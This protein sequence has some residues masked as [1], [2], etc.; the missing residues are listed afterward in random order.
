MGV[1]A[2]TP[3]RLLLAPVRVAIAEMQGKLGV[4]QLEVSTG[5]QADVTGLLGSAI[6][7]SIDLRLSLTT[8]EQTLDRIEQARTEATFLQSSLG[9][10]SDLTESFR[11][12][13]VSSRGTMSHGNLVLSAA[14]SALNTMQNTL[15]STYQG[16]FLFSGLNSDTSS[17]ND[18]N[19][20]PRAAIVSAFTAEFGF[21]PEDPAA[22]GLTAAQIK[23]FLQGGFKALFNDLSWHQDWSNATDET[24]SLRLDHGGGILTK[25]SANASFVRHMAA[26][27][28][29]VEVLFHGKLNRDAL[30]ATVDSAL[31]TISEAEAAIGLEQTRIGAA[32]SR[33]SAAAGILES[34]RLHFSAAIE[35]V[36]GVD[37]YEAATR[38]NMLMAQLEASY[39]LTARISRMSLL[40]YL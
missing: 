4:A 19:Q 1:S 14:Q 21:S 26:A 3:S 18:Y 20:K 6:G 12:S 13:L 36:E 8:T 17:I 30:E 10:L 31:I 2:F 32:E 39:T 23:G 7:V 22:A 11:S 34:R 5:R 33:L 16:H 24:V 28:S 9:H 25:T 35:E 40:S 27:F 37:S 38:V 29:M 15:N